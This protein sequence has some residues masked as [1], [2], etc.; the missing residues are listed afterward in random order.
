MDSGNRSGLNPRIID[1]AVRAMGLSRVPSTAVKPKQLILPG[2]KKTPGRNTPCPCGSGV[3][4]KK[5]CRPKLRPEPSRRVRPSSLR[6]REKPYIAGATVEEVSQSTESPAPRQITARA[7]LRAGVDVRV[8]WAYL[9]TGLYITEV[10]T[11]A[12]P[13]ENIEKWDAACQAYDEATPEER[14]ILAVS[15][16]DLE[17]KE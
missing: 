9:E 13:P 14:A 7:M 15:T 1:G 10:N 3:K 16:E 11:A 6:P 12:H 8:V 4:F 5:C 17:P 2:G